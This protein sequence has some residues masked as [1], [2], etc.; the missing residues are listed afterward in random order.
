MSENVTPKRCPQCGS[1]IPADA[2]QGL[3]PKC[4]LG[5]VSAPTESGQPAG[6]PELP[7]LD[8]IRAAF[9]QLEVVD[10]IGEGG[11][12]CV[13]KA[14]QP[15]LDR[16]VALKLL[17]PKLGADP[18]FAERFNR[19][20]RV[21][22]RL[23]HPNNVGVYDFGQAGGFYYLLMEYVDGVNLRQAMRSGRFSPAEALSLVPRICDALQYAHEEGVLHRDIKPENILLDTRGRLKIADFGIAKLFGQARENANLTATGVAVGTPHYMAPEQLERPQDVDQRADIYS[24]GVVFYEMLTGELPVGRFAPPSQKATVDPRVDDVV[25]R[26]LEKERGKRYRSAGEVK[27]RVEDIRRTPPPV[28]PHGT[29]AAGGGP[30]RRGE[31][32]AVGAGVAGSF[33]VAPGA[34]GPRW[35]KLAVVGAIVDAVAFVPALGL[36]VMVP[37]LHIRSVGPPSSPPGS[38]AWAVLLLGACLAAIPCLI[39]TIL[40]GAGLNRIRCSGNQ[41]RGRG[42]GLCAA[43]SWPLLFVNLLVLFF[44]IRFV[45]STMLPGRSLA[46]AVVPAA[47]VIVAALDFLIAVLVWRWAEP[48]KDQ[49]ASRFALPV[50]LCTLLVLALPT[51][52]LGVAV[53]IPV[54]VIR[55]AEPV[56]PAAAAMV[57]S[58]GRGI[59]ADFTLP[60]GQVAV[61]EI[62]TRKYDQ[63]VPVPNLAA[64]VL[65][66]VDEPSSGIF[67]WVPEQWESPTDERQG[68][69]KIELDQG[70]SKSSAGGYIVPEEIATFSGEQRLSTRLEPDQE[71]IHWTS[72]GEETR[73]AVGLRIRTQAYQP[74]PG[75]RLHSAGTGT[76]WVQALSQ[77]H[78]VSS[79]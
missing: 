56:R 65:T 47:L 63:V 27:T 72:E 12:G 36:L 6:H 77:N 73:P 31:V 42:L 1:P 60:A 35:S 34:T 23:N 48:C 41:L 44:A 67:R 53:W 61:F 11:M 78:G 38:P 46:F 51:F 50:V 76:N 57:N 14:R 7:P 43:L 62:V 49:P 2:P 5:G 75:V 52:F 10:L 71:V 66:P 16:L 9:P 18:A 28:G 64:Y 8:K 19:E 24:L 13:Y 33:R 45:N 69:W 59:I 26:A 15:R 20:A 30:P 54:T 29:V 3:C 17:W 58:A 37:F 40:G 4:V 21:L 74:K 25:L 22:A 68:L 55:H 39:G 79:P 70:G 32:Q